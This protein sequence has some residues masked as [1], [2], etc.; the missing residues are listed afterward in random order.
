[1]NEI[2]GAQDEGSQVVEH[3]LFVAEGIWAGYSNEVDVLRG[4]DLVLGDGELVSIIGPN[5]AGKSTLVKAMFG[6]VEVREGRVML[7]GEDVTGLKAHSLVAHG[8]GY[9]PQTSNVFPRLS[10]EENLE[11]GAYLHP[12]IIDQQMELLFDWFPLLKERRKQRAGSLSGGQRQL[13]A[14]ARALMANPDVLLLDEPSAGLSPANVDEIFERVEE[15]NDRG[16]SILIVEQN[17]RRGLAMADRGYVLEQGA[18][19]FTGEGIELLHDPKVAELYLGG[20]PDI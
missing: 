2:R 11:M 8:V 16:I 5:G 4:V 3:P 14:V 19:R 13:V 15:I 18:N 20:G 12:D 10:I 6:L 17:A 9:V 7:K 1:M